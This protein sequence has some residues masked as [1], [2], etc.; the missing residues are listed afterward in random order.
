M[1]REKNLFGNVDR[2]RVHNTKTPVF[3]RN[4][5]DISIARLI[6]TNQLRFTMFDLHTRI[7]EETIS[8]NTHLS[9]QSINTMLSKNRLFLNK[10]DQ[11]VISNISLEHMLL[12]LFFTAMK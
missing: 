3:L 2:R 5:H 6:E 4:E 12:T 11:D 7:F 9:H 10:N 1:I 8:S